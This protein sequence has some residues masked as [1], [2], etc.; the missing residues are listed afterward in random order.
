MYMVAIGGWQ[1]PTQRPVPREAREER[2]CRPKGCRKTCK[3]KE[4]RERNFGSPPPSP[5]SPDAGRMRHR[6]RTG[7]AQYCPHEPARAIVRGRLPV[8]SVPR[9]CGDPSWRHHVTAA[10]RAARAIACAAVSC[11]ACHPDPWEHGRTRY[12]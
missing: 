11:A 8:W 3:K 6:R 2:T 1:G 5:K 10:E 7:E 9:D 12:D 4:R